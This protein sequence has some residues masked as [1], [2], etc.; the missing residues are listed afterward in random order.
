MKAFRLSILLLLALIG[1]VEARAQQQRFFNL[2]VDDIAIDSMLP[3]FSYAIPLGKHYEDSIYTLEI[4]YP[5]FL[6][7]GRRDSLR[8][9]ALTQEEPGRLPKIT[10]Q[11]VVDRKNGR[12]D[13]T[14]CP[15]VRR[16]GQLKFLVSFMVALT[17]Q[18][19]QPPKPREKPVMRLLARPNPSMLP[20]P[21]CAQDGGSRS[22]FRP[23]ASTN[24][25]RN[26]SGK[27]DLATSTT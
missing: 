26:W 7:M 27:P 14:L 18:P 13:F 15:V 2:T 5:E 3:R 12:L 19:S 22:A 4:R 6:D 8:Y 21:C 1:G 11:I 16:D 24:S 10:Q 17:S 23:R 25:P 9:L 20:T